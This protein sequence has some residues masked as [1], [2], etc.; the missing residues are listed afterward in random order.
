[1]AG[2]CLPSDT[3][4]LV[5]KPTRMHPSHRRIL[6]LPRFG[7]LTVVGPENLVTAHQV[8]M[9]KKLWPRVYRLATQSVHPDPDA[10][11]RLHA[12]TE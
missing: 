10:A 2:Q 9:V 1:M 12:R 5:G 11:T 3:E 4:S 8:Q 6:E 7:G